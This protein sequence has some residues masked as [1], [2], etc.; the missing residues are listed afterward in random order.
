MAELV[1]CP[2]VNCMP[3]LAWNKVVG[4]VLCPALL[5]HMLCQ[6][7]VAHCW[8][9]KTQAGHGRLHVMLLVTQQVQSAQQCHRSTQ[10]MA[11]KANV[12]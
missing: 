2:V 10:G 11:C 5:L 4:D 6:C 12:H 8:S 1:L 7:L 3:E 9:G